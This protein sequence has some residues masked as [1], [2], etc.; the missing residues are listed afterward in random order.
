MAVQGRWSHERHLAAEPTSAFQARAFVR[1]HLLAHDLANM[2]GEIQLVVSELA[3]N[4]VLHAQ[5]PFTV[6][7][8]A[9][10][11]TLRLEVVDGSNVMPLMVVAGPLDLRGR[12]MATVQ[13]LS[14]DWGVLPRT[15]DGKSVWAEFD[16]PPPH[17]RAL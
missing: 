8:R 16:I 6:S 5:T 11:S 15:S 7:L 1:R 3:S 12:G 4:A 14:Q 13:A 9:F 17:T 10:D 2:V